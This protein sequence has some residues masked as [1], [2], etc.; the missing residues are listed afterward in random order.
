MTHTKQ[1]DMLE[2]NNG[3]SKSTIKNCYCTCSSP[4]VCSKIN[5]SLEDHEN[6]SDESDNLVIDCSD[7]DA[8]PTFEINKGLVKENRLIRSHNNSS[9]ITLRSGSSYCT[10]ENSSSMSPPRKKRKHLDE[11]EVNSNNSKPE[12]SLA[13]SMNCCTC[14]KQLY[15]QDAFK[16]SINRDNLTP[17]LSCN[18]EN[19]KNIFSQNLLN[20]SGGT[21]FLGSKSFQSD[22]SPDKKY[23]YHK[24][25]ISADRSRADGGGLNILKSESGMRPL[26]LL[27]R[28]KVDGYKVNITFLKCFLF[29]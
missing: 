28:S 11:A 26:S 13:S 3:I 9:S 24:W 1:T 17:S 12:G 25:K 22:V 4:N 2:D 18:Y 23:V 7:D 20:S 19:N 14:G 8:M 27:I 21:N 15:Y 16:K 5:D 10:S 29:R 6:E